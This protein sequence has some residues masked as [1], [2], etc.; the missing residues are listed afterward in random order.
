MALDDESS[1]RSDSN[2]SDMIADIELNANLMS[3][4]ESVYSDVDVIV[5][6]ELNAETETDN[7]ENYEEVAF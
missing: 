1:M 4:E 3:D 6:N 5:N 2:N 7:D